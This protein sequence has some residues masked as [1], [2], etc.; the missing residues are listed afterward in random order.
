MHTHYISWWNLENLFD[1]KDAP[2]DRRPEDLKRKIKAD[3][4]NWTPEVLERKIQNLASVINQINEGEGPDIMG[5]CEVENAHVLNLLIDEIDTGKNYG[6]IHHNMKDQRGIDV[7]FLYN[8]DKYTFVS[9]E[10]FHHEVIKRY[11][12]REIVQATLR[13]KA[14]GR[15]LILVGNHWPS[16]S[17]GK[18]DSEPYRIITGE[19]LSYFCER[20]QEIK[21]DDAAIIVMGDF[22]DEPFSR[23]MEDYALSVVDRNKVVY[24]Q[25]PYLYNLMW[26]ILGER[27]ASYVFGSNVIMLDQF[28]VAKGIAK[29]SGNYSLDEST[30]KL[31]IF[32]GMVSGR[33]NTPV[34]FGQS[35][36][37]LDGFSDHLPI[38]FVLGEKN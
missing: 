35:K 22:N 7:A 15:E 29:K 3:L 16:R 31:E 34:R 14:T 26:P 8:K 4:K 11:P 33:Y 1:E 12:T 25:N 38:S 5:V 23:S 2:I 36:P 20:I 28:L 30:V 9:K 18:Y 19:T 13:V 10:F 21:G 32:D 24:G 17:A 27:K 37:N 6:L